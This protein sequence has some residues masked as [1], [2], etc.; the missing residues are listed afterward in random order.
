MWLHKDNESLLIEKREFSSFKKAFG[1]S[2]ERNTKR[3]LLGI[4]L[5]LILFLLLPWDTEYSSTGIVNDTFT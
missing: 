3:W 5:V 4:T 2:D 1:D